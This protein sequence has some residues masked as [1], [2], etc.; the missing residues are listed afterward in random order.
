MTIFKNLTTKSIQM[1]F[2]VN[3]STFHIPQYLQ[4]EKKSLDC[5]ELT[6]FQHTQNGIFQGILRHMIIRV[7]ILSRIKRRNSRKSC[8]TPKFTLGS[9]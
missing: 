5:I 3:K 9:V 2:K 1:C 7:D 8:K 6:V 4:N